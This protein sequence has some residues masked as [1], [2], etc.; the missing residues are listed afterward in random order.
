MWPK[1]V[2]DFY[3]AQCVNKSLEPKFL[4]RPPGR[5]ALEVYESDL[6]WM[7]LDLDIP[8]EE[9]Y[10]EALPW[11]TDMIEQEYPSLFDSR[12]DK[13]EQIAKQR[14]WKTVCVHGLS[15][16]Q[17][18]RPT[19]Y[20]YDNEDEVPY[21]WTEV[22]DASP[23]TKEFLQSLPYEKLYRARFTCIMPGG[24]SAPHIGRKEGADYSHK[25]NFAL[26]HPP[27]W[28]FWLENQGPIP[29]EAGRGFLINADEYYH[30]VVNTSNVPRIHLITMGKPD[31]KRF[32]ELFQKSY[33]G[34]DP[35]VNA[36]DWAKNPDQLP[37]QLTEEEEEI[38][39]HVNP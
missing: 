1:S 17:F 9:M 13:N 39:L 33:Y 16:H 36:Y 6:P 24:F 28:T 21:K 25:I 3:N 12:F 26:N 37:T 11:V 2:V 15:K 22:A 32:E 10:K 18:D 30:S 35:K 8:H 5:N 4:E 31:W 29:F 23:V 7:A 20:G 14:Q 38:S 34:L 19:V 27:G